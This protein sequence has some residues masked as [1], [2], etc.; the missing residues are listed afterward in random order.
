MSDVYYCNGEFVPAAEAAVPVD[1][2]ALL[3]GFGVFEFLRT[4]NGRPFGLDQHLARLEGSARFISLELPM[5]LA[6]IAGVVH[7]TLSRNSHPESNIRIVVTGGSSP[8]FITPSDN[9]R[10]IVMVTAL[11]R[12]PEWWYE[13]GV[14][15]ALVPVSRAFPRAKS[16]A[17][18]Q[19]VVSMR[20][21]REQGAVEALYVDRENRVLEGTTSN[22]FIVSGGELVT[23]E[24]GVLPGVTRGVV[25]EIAA[26]ILPVTRR[27]IIRDELFRAEEIFITA[28]NKEVVPVVAVDEAP[29]GDGAPGP[30]TKRIM[31]AFAR[32]VGKTT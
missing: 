22:V 6:D 32:R 31:E 4:Y 23:P 18:V 15:V 17:Y 10:L 19:A 9:P 29:V 24:Q 14:K 26:G 5:S 30:M 27:S 25:L 12:C 20:A 2:L 28:T 8:D 11:R 3:R 16:I 13:R 7:E 1:D 21:A